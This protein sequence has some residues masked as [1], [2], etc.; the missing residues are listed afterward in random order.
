[1]KK[2]LIPF[3]AALLLLSFTLGGDEIKTLEIGQDAPQKDLTLK[4][5][6]KQEYTL[7]SAKLENGLLVVFSCNT[8]PFVVGNGDTEGWEG[9]YN[10][11]FEEA[12]KHNI[13]MLL[14]NSNEAKRKK[15]DS[16]KDMV[17]RA[18]SKG[19]KATYVLDKNH[20]LADAFGAKTTPHVFLFDKD[21]KLAYTGAIDDNVDNSEMVEEHFVKNAMN[22]LANGQK[23]MPDKTRNIGCS[24]K[25]V[26][27]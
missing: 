4:G 25:R 16:M 17:E 14:V 20:V 27:K 12:K 9:R 1:M 15:G 19:L 22:S 3:A 13:G 21:L 24:I 11:V 8:C 23:I 7:E 2:L 5:I 26:S 18:K 6:D 10:A